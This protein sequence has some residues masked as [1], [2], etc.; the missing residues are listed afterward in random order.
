MKPF[1][2]KIKDGEVFLGDGALGTML[3]QRG[4]KAGE[5]PDIWNIEKPGILEEIASLYI[6]AG[7][8]IISANTFGGHP[9]KLE[10]YGLHDK[11]EIINKAGVGAIK[12]AIKGK[13]YL[14]ASCG[15]SGKLLKPYGDTDP[16][17]ISEGYI[18][19]LGAL[20]EEGVDVVYFETMIDLAEAL[21]GVK[22]AK[23]IAPG[24]PVCAT[25]TFD[26]GPNGFFTVM[27]NSIEQTAK[28]LESAGADVV[29]SNCGNGIDNMVKIAE[30]F[31]KHSDLPVLIQS[32][33]GLP[34]VK[35]D[36]L[37]Y[38][39]TPDFMAERVKTLL[40]MGINIIGGCCGTTPEHIA[41]FR[42]TIDNYR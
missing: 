12:D 10:Q 11:T 4:L 14:A 1:L 17:D 34:I 21:L 24:V 3:I 40:D 2:Q 6:D 33:A 35:D 32:N 29:G 38:P 39:E 41:S 18:R 22:A 42:K 13:A 31:K 37:E 25:M 20:I 28:E 16:E 26:L 27:G 7:S 23:S 8:D 15:P 19:Q 5:C 30:E 9:L 36:I